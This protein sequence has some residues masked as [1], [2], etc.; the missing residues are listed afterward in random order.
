MRV[1][2]T[3]TIGDT[4]SDGQS[5]TV[6]VNGTTS[7]DKI[8]LSRSAGAIVVDGLAAEVRIAHADPILD[9]LVVNGLGG[10]DAIELASGVDTA[11]SVTLNP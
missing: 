2:L 5:Q 9:Q 1:D 11:I 10:G 8:N 4:L 6:I 3:G 7:T